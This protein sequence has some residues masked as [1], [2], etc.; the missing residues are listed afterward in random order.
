L[1]L[2][3]FREANKLP[4]PEAQ[5]GAGVSLLAG[6]EGKLHAKQME[7]SSLQQVA[8]NENIQVKVVQAE[9]V[10]LQG[11]I[12]K[13]RDE[14]G[15]NLTALAQA[16]T[17]YYNLYRDEKT[18]EILYQVYTRYM[19]ELTIDELSARQGV[20]M[21]EPPFINPERQFN[22]LSVGMLLLVILAALG[23]EF[24]LAR[25]PRRSV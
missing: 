20:D 7:L 17:Q 2:N 5:L 4:A 23:A 25:P 16:N 15:Q 14:G 13:V 21:I 9:I 1:A 24:Y 3:A 18:A 10:T 6:L 22:I 11:Q 19:E 12:A 8:T